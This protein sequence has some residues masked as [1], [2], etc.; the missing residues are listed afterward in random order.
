MYCHLIRIASYPALT[1]ILFILPQIPN[2]KIKT[3]AAIVVLCLAAQGEAFS[4]G[5]LLGTF[6]VFMCLH[7]KSVG[8][9]NHRDW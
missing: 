8:L 2:M 6:R 5:K 1:Q 3:R 9:W 7:P 4:F